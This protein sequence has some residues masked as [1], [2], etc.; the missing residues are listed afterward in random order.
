ANEFVREAVERK[1]LELREQLTSL[2]VAGDLARLQQI[3]TNLLTNA[4]QFTPRKGRITVSLLARGDEAVLTVEDTGAGIEPAF[5]PYV[6]DQFRQ[7]EGG[8]ARTHGGLG[9]GLT[10]VK[11]LVELHGGTVTVDSRGTG[12]GATFIVCLPLERV[13]AEDRAPGDP[14]LLQD[15][16]VSVVAAEGMETSMLRSILEASGA[17]V[18]VANGTST[19]EAGS[20]PDV[21]LTD[22]GSDSWTL[23]FSQSNERSQSLAKSTSPSD[24]VRR[25]ARMLKP[26]NAR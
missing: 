6:F 17:T 10:V 1:D 19:P 14:L 23:N 12:Q 11:Q 21:T 26:S 24:I 18:S 2:S 20:H 3:V 7:G 25:I 4:V 13:L 16:N 15:V 22:A 5:L 9:L 8:L